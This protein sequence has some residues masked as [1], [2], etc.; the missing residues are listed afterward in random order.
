[1]TSIFLSPTV[2]SMTVNS[3]FSSAAAAPAPAGPAATATAAAAETPHFSSSI[4]A[5]SAASR[6]VSFD[7][8]STIFCKS[9]IFSSY[10]VRTRDCVSE[11]SGRLALG[12]I[13]LDHARDLGR[14]SVGELRD[15]GRRRHEEADDL[16]AQFVQRRQRGERLDAVRIQSRLAHRP[17]ENDE[18]LVRLGEIDGDL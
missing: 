17:A 2:V 12:C 10:Q 9:A 5:R 4:L 18:L 14:G 13:S 7:S 11:P 8:S 16:G 1:M 6:T 15:L 3:V